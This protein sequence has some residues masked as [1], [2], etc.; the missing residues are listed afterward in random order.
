MAEDFVKGTE[1]D[2]LAGL[3][4]RQ[5]DQGFTA[6]D[7]RI[8]ELGDRFGRFEET[9]AKTL[10]EHGE[11]IAVLTERSSKPMLIVPADEAAAA[12][13]QM[14]TK[15]AAVW[16]TGAGTV[17]VF[18]WSALKSAAAWVLGGGHK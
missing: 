18:L 5:I 7:T 15:R 3:V 4:S 1:L 8:T 10:S 12:R 17:A 9:V 11:K 6:V 14:T 16:G 13:R 2:R